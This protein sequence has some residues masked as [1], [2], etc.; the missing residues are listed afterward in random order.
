[1]D[2]GLETAEGDEA[3][4]ARNIIPL[5]GAGHCWV[6]ERLHRYNAVCVNHCMFLDHITWCD[7]D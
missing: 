5:S 1:M 4:T 6:I 3:A 2:P 7:C